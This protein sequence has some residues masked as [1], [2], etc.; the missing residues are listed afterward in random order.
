MDLYISDL[1]GTLLNSDAKISNYTEESLNNLIKNTNLNFSIATARTPA[2][3]VP[4][5]NNLNITLPIVV[6]NGAGIYDLK[7]SKYISYNS[8]NRNLV[9]E[10]LLIL[11]KNNISPFIYTLLD[12]HINTYYEKDNTAFQENFIKLR[13][14]SPYKTF[15]EGPLPKDSEV[16]YF[17]IMDTKETVLKT[18]EKI[19]KL[20]GLYSVAYK[21]VYDESIYNLEIYSDKSSKANSI[22]YIMDKFNFNRLISFGD[23]LNDLPM[24]K[25]SDECYSVENASD[26]LKAISTS[27]INSNVNDGVSKFL[28]N[29][30]IK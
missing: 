23:N 8:I 4:I 28:E 13:S 6:M 16:L 2:T 21:D 22:K 20:D 17:F 1:D 26:E 18:Y 19:K 15:I 30:F 24:F 10:I 5:L 12:H 7:N 29:R 14:G 3:V 27:I 11:S 9:N 25:L